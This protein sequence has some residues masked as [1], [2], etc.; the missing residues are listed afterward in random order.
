MKRRELVLATA[1]VG[2]IS[3][4]LRSS[5]VRTDGSDDHHSDSDGDSDGDDHRSRPPFDVSTVDAPGSEAG[6]ISVPIDEYVLLL[7]F[8]RT[9]CPTSEEMIATIREARDRLIEEYDGEK[10][11]PV[12]FLSVV[13]PVLGLDPTASELADWWDEHD[14]N[15]AVGVDDGGLLNEYYDVSGFPTTIAMAGDGSV[16]WRS[17]HGTAPSNVVTGVRT[18]LEAQSTEWGRDVDGPR[19]LR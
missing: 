8:T 2:A 3:G 6:T 18:A 13:D 12:R 19:R 15:W 1:T 9:E 5:G 14:G 16:H 17:T 4:C 7:N 10:N 11:I